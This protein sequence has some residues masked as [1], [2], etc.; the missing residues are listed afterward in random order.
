MAIRGIK[1]LFFSSFLLVISSSSCGRLLVPLTIKAVQLIG[2][3]GRIIG[4]SALGV[5]TERGIDAII[6]WWSGEDTPEQS[7]T[8]DT[9]IDIIPF[10]DNLYKGY[11]RG[12]FNIRVQA[13]RNGTETSADIPIKEGELI[14]ERLDTNS[15]WSMTMESERF[16]K[17][18]T[19][20][21]CAQ[22][23]LLGLGY[24]PEGVDGRIGKR[25]RRAIKAFQKDKGLFETGKLDN[26]TLGELLEK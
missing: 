21:G 3:A 22:L 6:T 12:S 7:D 15:S 25:S 2:Q 10:R 14:Y 17:E 5:L 9:G 13:V 8:E 11:A 19:L 26:S 4:E 16:L 24:D 20:N 23:S 18:L 1:I